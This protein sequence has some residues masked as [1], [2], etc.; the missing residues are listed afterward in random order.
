[1]VQTKI[2]DIDESLISKRSR[3]RWWSWS[4]L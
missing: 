4:S 2:E 1:L 3:R